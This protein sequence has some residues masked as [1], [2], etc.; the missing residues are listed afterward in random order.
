MQYQTES[1]RFSG[2]RVVGR[3]A[4]LLGAQRPLADEGPPETTTIRL[5]FTTAICFA[6]L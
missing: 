3:A 4:G 1:P 2:Q 6:P 5:A